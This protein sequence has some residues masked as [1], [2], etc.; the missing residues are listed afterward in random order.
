MCECS[1]V[2]HSVEAVVDKML[3]I[4]TH[5]NLSH[6]F[7]LVAIHASQ[8]ADMCKY[9]LKSVGQLQHYTHSI[10]HTP[11]SEDKINVSQPYMYCLSTFRPHS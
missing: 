3:E 10:M 11:F 2:T 5:A 8:L 1:R 4:L 9:V 6:Q 7:V